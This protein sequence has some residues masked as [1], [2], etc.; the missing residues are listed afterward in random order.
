[1]P[2]KTEQISNLPI[3]V[4]HMLPPLTMPQDAENIIVDTIA[5]MEKIKRPIYRVMDFTTTNLQF[6]DMVVGMSYDKGK[7]GG[8][9]DPDITTIFV[10]SDEL[11]KF[12]TEA[13]MNQDH[14]KGAHVAGLATSVDEAIEMARS[15]LAKE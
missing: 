5:L 13:M 4:C 11:V 2:T 3:V 9:Y 14:F 15:L 10:G 7:K 8:T 6:S 1:M 12:G